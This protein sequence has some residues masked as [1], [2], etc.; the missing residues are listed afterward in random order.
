MLLENSLAFA[1]ALDAADPL[2]GFRTEF[3]IPT[4]D[5]KEQI[6]FL[7]NS[8]GL[9]PKRTPL[10]IMQVL[11]QW[12]QYGVEAFFTGEQP[13]LHYH[14]QLVQPLSKIVGAL[15]NEIV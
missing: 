1:K 4:E 14:D 9:Q 6:Y 13:W 15:P 5:E 7:G 12:K 10:Y 8:L 3:I 11:E 2:R